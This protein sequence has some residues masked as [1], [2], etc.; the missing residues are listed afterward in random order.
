VAWVPHR[1]VQVAAAKEGLA[2][3]DPVIPT[4]R[5]RYL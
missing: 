4:K 1:L 5:G 3:D 2:T